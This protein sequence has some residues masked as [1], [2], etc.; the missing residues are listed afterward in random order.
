MTF[1]P[2]LKVTPVTT[3]AAELLEEELD[4]LEEL[5]EEAAL[6]EEDAELELSAALEE[7]ALEEL[8]E[9]ALL[10][11]LLELAALLL[12]VAAEELVVVELAAVLEAAFEDEVVVP[13]QAHKPNKAAVAK[14]KITF[15]FMV[16]S[17]TLQSVGSIVECFTPMDNVFFSLF[18]RLC[19]EHKPL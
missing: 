9:A 19:D 13:P 4:E 14:V 11:A 3:G 12:E 15:V 7:A 5:E 10:A 1:S 18:L 8:E 2:S 17:I 6:L 16:K